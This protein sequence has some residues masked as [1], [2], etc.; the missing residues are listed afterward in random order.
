RV[1]GALE[2]ALDAGLE[3]DETHVRR[4]RH[5]A[6]LERAAVE[7]DR[8]APAAED[9]AGLVEDPAG[10]A[11]GPELGALAGERQLE[12]LELEVGDDAEGERD[13]DLERGRRREARTRR[14]VRRDRALEPDR[15]TPERGQL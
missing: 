15:R 13:R 4:H 1:A 9:R 12:R 10:H 5:E 7:Q 8:S 2:P 3:D 14:E 6:M 11:D